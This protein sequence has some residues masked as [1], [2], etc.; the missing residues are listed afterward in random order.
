MWKQAVDILP[1]PNSI[2]GMLFY[3]FVVYLLVFLLG[4]IFGRPAPADAA[5]EASKSEDAKREQA[6]TAADGRKQRKDAAETK[7]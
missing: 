4:V 3:S 6:K 2:L 5:T 7:N 1:Q